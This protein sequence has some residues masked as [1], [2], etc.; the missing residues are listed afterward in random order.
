[1]SQMYVFFSRKNTQLVPG[2]MKTEISG[3]GEKVPD[4]D[5]WH[6]SNCL[7]SFSAL[8]VCVCDWCL[9]FL[10]FSATMLGS[11]WLTSLS[12]LFCSIL[13]SCAF[14]LMLL[15]KRT[16]SARGGGLLIRS[17]CNLHLSERRGD[18][19]ER[20]KVNLEDRRDHPRQWSRPAWW[21]F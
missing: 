12:D 14:V 10:K 7:A 16:V 9:L 20:I 3:S 4:P 2:E 6:F 17:P 5:P 21:R 1:M 11:I 15:T 19:I 18:R 13:R 8:C